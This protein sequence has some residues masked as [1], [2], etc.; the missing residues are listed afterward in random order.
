MWLRVGIALL[1]TAI[2][3]A[4]GWRAIIRER[5]PSARDDALVRWDER[6]VSV[7]RQDWRVA[8]LIAFHAASIALLAVLFLLDTTWGEGKATLFLLDA[9]PYMPSAEVRTFNQQLEL[10]ATCGLGMVWVFC[11]NLLAFPLARRWGRPLAHGIAP[12]G[13]ISGPYLLLWSAFSH[14]SADPLTRLIRFYSS[15]TPELACMAWRPPNGDL[16]D[17]AVA[18]LGLVLP[19]G[20]PQPQVSWYRRRSVLL[21]LL[22]LA[23]TLPFVVAGLLIYA[24]AFTWGWMYYT[25]VTPLL[26]GLGLVVFRQF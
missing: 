24:F 1:G 11:G 5:R 26:V 9:T 13:A 15:R 2:G 21:S 20:P 7:W 18:F 8:S 23:G 6:S 22:L 12:S 17:Q 14:F 16:F 10:I 3:F 19:E 25:F 4:L